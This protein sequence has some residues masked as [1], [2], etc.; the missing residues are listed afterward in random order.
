[1]KRYPEF[2]IIPLKNPET[3]TGKIFFGIIFIEEINGNVS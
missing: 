1:V 2:K 3:K